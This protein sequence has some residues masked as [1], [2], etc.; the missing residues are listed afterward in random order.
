M[1]GLQDGVD[2][3]RTRNCGRAQVADLVAVEAE[4]GD[5][6]AV[7]DRLGNRDRA[8]VTDLVEAELEVLQDEERRIGVTLTTP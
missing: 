2:L 1:E 5:D 7:F 3:E 6:G 4:E 8:A